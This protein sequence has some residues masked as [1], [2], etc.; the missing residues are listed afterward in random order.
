MVMISDIGSAVTRRL[1]L[2]FVCILLSL[3]LAWI[4]QAQ[5]YS[6][7]SGGVW[8]DGSTWQGGVIPTST[9]Q[10]VIRGIVSINASATVAQVTVESGA[11][12][13][14]RLDRT[15]TVT[16]DLTN[17]GTIR[18]RYSGNWWLY[19]VIGGD[20]TNNGTW[21]NYRTTLNGSGNQTISQAAGINWG[22]Q[23]VLKTTS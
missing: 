16:R 7:P 2:V 21:T 18:D 13:R 14:G 6:V 11:T 17:N 15:L 3:S 1:Q 23:I 4:S 10:V 19:L 8:A 20:V 12:L 5:V 22:T 9:D